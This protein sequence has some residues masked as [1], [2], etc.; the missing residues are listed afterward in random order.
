MKNKTIQ[1]IAA[2]ALAL[3]LT[4]SIGFAQ[5]SASATVT[6]T[7]LAPLAVSGTDMSFDDVEPGRQK[8]VARTSESAGT[9]ALT[10]RASH[11]IT[12]TFTLP[13]NVT[14]GAD[15][16]PIS[17]SSTDGGFNTANTQASA[18]PFDPSAIQIWN[19]IGT[20]AAYVWLGATVTPTLSQAGGTYS[21]MVE[22][23]V[24]YTGN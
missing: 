16:L 1:L 5:E 12:A 6:A 2:V 8:S 20:G 21:G 11:E 7:V 17:F 13:S 18:A 4:V 23:T 10:G 22:L 9:F 19:F 14:N 24:D 3:T 15:L